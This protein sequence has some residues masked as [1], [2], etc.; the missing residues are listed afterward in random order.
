MIRMQSINFIKIVARSNGCWMARIVNLQ[1]VKL[2]ILNRFV[3][4]SSLVEFL[5]WQQGRNITTKETAIHLFQTRTS[6]G[7]PLTFSSPI[8]CPKR[9]R[10]STTLKLLA[11]QFSEH[12]RCAT[13]QLMLLK[14]R[15]LALWTSL[16]LGPSRVQWLI[17]DSGRA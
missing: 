16:K 1:L 14:E 3:Q 13:T 8:W 12:I 17:I 11:A 7:R 15:S 2:L 4:L 5:R 9:K 6:C 10:P